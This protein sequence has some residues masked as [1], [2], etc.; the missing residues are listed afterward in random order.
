MRRRPHST[1]WCST[2]LSL[3]SLAMNRGI[4]ISQAGAI[5]GTHSELHISGKIMLRPNPV[6]PNP[7]ISWLGLGDNHL[8]MAQL[9]RLVKYY[10]L[11][12]NIYI[13]IYI[14]IYKLYIYIYSINLSY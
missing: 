10:N 8:Q 1:H 4:G 7:G 14:Y 9:F 5:P 3:S 6:L 13:Y 11:P 2:L 12:I